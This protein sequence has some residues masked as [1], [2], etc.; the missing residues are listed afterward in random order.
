MQDLRQDPKIVVCLMCGVEKDYNRDFYHRR[1]KP[2]GKICRD[3][4]I[5]QV[6]ARQNLLRLGVLAPVRRK[7][8]RS[9]G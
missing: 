2:S 5:K 8:A 7:R 4:K 6:K 9:A 3:C 1:G